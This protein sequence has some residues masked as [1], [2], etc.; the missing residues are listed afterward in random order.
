MKISYI[1][2]I[3]NFLENITAKSKSYAAE[4]CLAPSY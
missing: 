3:S 4:F 1:D 2:I